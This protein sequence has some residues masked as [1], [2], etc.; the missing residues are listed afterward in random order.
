MCRRSIFK[1]LERDVS[2]AL[3]SKAAVRLVPVRAAHGVLLTRT[4]WFLSL[5]CCLRIIER[6]S[7]LESADTVC[8]LPALVLR[9]RGGVQPLLTSW[10]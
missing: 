3:C 9:S 4:P 10:F 6:W 8:S 5:E 2:S 1:G 7:T